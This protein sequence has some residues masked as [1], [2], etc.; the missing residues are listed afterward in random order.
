MKTWASSKSAFWSAYKRTVNPFQPCWSLSNF[1]TQYYMRSHH[2]LLHSLASTSALAHFRSD[3]L[4]SLDLST[5]LSAT[6]PLLTRAATTFR[7]SGSVAHLNGSPEWLALWT[8]S[9]SAYPHLSIGKAA[10]KTAAAQ[11]EYPD[12][13]HYYD[14]VRTHHLAPCL[15]NDVHLKNQ[16]EMSPFRSSFYL[17][18]FH[19]QNLIHVIIYFFLYKMGYLSSRFFSAVYHTIMKLISEI[20]QIALRI[21]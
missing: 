11:P 19:P 4:P 9:I 1:M 6:H 21:K 8:M 18:I 13:L 2:P 12:F 5:P 15:H 14:P 7:F 3:F 16:F 17:N 20:A 10:H